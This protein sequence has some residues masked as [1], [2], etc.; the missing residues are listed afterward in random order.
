MDTIGVT[1]TLP[2]SFPLFRARAPWWGG[3]LQTMRNVL[4]GRPQPLAAY[5]GSRLL[6][7]LGDGSG[8]RLA[9]ALNRPAAALPRPLAVLVHGLGGAED[10]HY[11]VSTAAHLLSL[12]YPVLRL[13]LRGAGASRASCRLQ[14]HAGRTADFADALAALPQALTAAGLIAIGYSLGGN[15]LVKFLGERGGAAPLK[16]AVAVSTPLDLSACA[17][18]IRRPRNAL[19]QRYLLYAMRRESLG[20]GAEITA[21]ERAAIIDSRT[22]WEFDNRF[23]APRNGFA[24]AEDY[25]AR[26]ASRQFLDG[27]AVPTLVIHALDDPWIPPAPYLAHDWRRNPSLTLLLSRGGGHVGFQ[28]SDRR[29]P[30]H[31][32]CIAQFLALV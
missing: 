31:D 12:G 15:M 25:Y 8:D 2:P 14:Y 11:V 26:N 4:V 13:N 17:S 21:A 19:Y 16:A 6:L 23:V 29:I 18:E 30:W 3:D 7:P 20:E 10:S 27:I 9:G 22:V 5:P 24:G 28:G 32:L 1:K